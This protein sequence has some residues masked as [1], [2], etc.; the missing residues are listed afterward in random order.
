MKPETKRPRTFALSRALAVA[1]FASVATTS[2]ASAQQQDPAAG[3]APAPVTAGAE[4]TRAMLEKWVEARRQISKAR[5]DW[6]V[7]KEAVLE[8]ID[9][10]RRSIDAQKQRIVETEASIAAADRQKAAL[11]E[12]SSK[13]DVVQQALDVAIIAMEE[14]TRAL[15][16]RLPEPI[17]EK[18]APLTQ[19]F[20]TAQ[21]DDSNKKKLSLGVRFGNVLSVLNLVNKWNREVTVTSEIRSLPDGST[22]EVACLYLGLGQAFYVTIKGDAAGV[23]VAT[24]EGWKWT[25]RNDA[26]V[27]VQAAIKVYQ[28]KQMASFV[29]LPIEIL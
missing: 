25:P 28:S 10:V 2:Y 13:L 19:Q 29:A 22:A 6:R 17:R 23:G 12:E 8:R 14:Q 21:S 20:A 27:A 16:L 24:P 3:T 9:V 11:I 18:I 26:A 4:T 7:E 5:T 15:L 1:M